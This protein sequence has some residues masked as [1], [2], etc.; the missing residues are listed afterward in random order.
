MSAPCA[1]RAFVAADTVAT[2]GENFSGPG[3][4]SAGVFS[5]VAPTTPILIPPFST[6]IESLW[7]GRI[8]PSAS[9][10]FA[11]RTGN[12]ASPIRFK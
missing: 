1:F 8:E 3:E 9:R 12:F 10:R 11:A 2:V 4:E 5:S 7:P 6:I